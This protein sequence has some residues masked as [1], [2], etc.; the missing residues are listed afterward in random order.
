[1]TTAILHAHNPARTVSD[2]DI[3]LPVAA[4]SPGGKHARCGAE[5]LTSEG[6][7]LVAWWRPG[8]GKTP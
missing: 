4:W 5:A 2:D 1:M 6:G 8:R 7:M 3:A